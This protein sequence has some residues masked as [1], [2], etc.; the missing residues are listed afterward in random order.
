MKK[1]LSLLLVFLMVASLGV[2]V[3]EGDKTTISVAIFD[4]GAVPADKGSYEDNWVTQWIN[5]NAPVNVQFVPVP[6]WETYSTYSLWLASDTPTDVFME[7]QPDYVQVWSGEGVLYELGDLIDE[8]APNYRALTPQV[9]QDWGKYNNGEYAMVDARAETAVINWM[10][11][12]RAD[13]LENLGLDMPT[14]LDEIGRAH[15]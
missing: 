6:R 7:F 14:T 10:I 5:E 8:Y 15:V 1:Y 2:S 11:Y 3:A 9:V 12:I 13:W 4:R